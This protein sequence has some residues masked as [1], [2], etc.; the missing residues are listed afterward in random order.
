MQNI[1]NANAKK[2]IIGGRKQLRDALCLLLEKTSFVTVVSLDDD[3]VN[4]ATVRGAV[5][6]YES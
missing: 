6:I 4:N 5:K 1:C 2:V 3:T